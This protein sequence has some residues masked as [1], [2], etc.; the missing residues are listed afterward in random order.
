[1]KDFII[2]VDDYNI[3][4]Y[5]T[6]AK[7]V[8]RIPDDAERMQEIGRLVQRISED[9]PCIIDVEKHFKRYRGR[10]LPKDLSLVSL[11]RWEDY[12]NNEPSVCSGGFPM[13]F[14]LAD[15]YGNFK[16]WY[17]EEPP[18]RAIDRMWEQSMV[19]AT[20]DPIEPN[21]NTDKLCRLL[22]ALQTEYEVLR[23]SGIVPPQP[24]AFVM[25]IRLQ[26][27]RARA[28]F[29]KFADEGYLEIIDGGRYKWLKNKLALSV[30]AEQ[31][32]SRLRLR[33]KTW[34]VFSHL[35]IADFDT[36]QLQSYYKNHADI[37]DKNIKYK[38]Y[39]TDPDCRR[40]R[41]IFAMNKF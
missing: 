19:F 13:G 10:S 23:M 29:E 41:L 21:D 7:S 5:D 22:T 36:G 15:E 30:F 35:F 14:D 38:I 2:A 3:S 4:A 26:S 9:W 24:E 6:K 17:G 28:I 37:W 40:I 11:Y 18:P 33:G 16:T 20:Y 39:E 12:V 34:S 8:M 25:D 27:D 1:M 32:I 31:T